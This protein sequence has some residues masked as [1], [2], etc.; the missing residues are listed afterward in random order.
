MGQNTS[1]INIK[2]LLDASDVKAKVQDIQNAFKSIKLPDN[3]SK[4]FNNA[5]DN[6]NKAISNYES[7][8]AKGVKTQTDAKGIVSSVDD[9][10]KQFT[11]VE[12]I[13][14]KIRAEIGSGID[15]SSM[16]K[17]DDA[18]LQKIDTLK[19]KIA[20]LQSQLEKVTKD[21][22]G[23]LGSILDKIS[24]KGAKNTAEKAIDL[25][26]TGK[27]KEAIALL[28]QAKTKQQQIIDAQKRDENNNPLGPAFSES[29]RATAE[30]NITAFGQLQ[31]V[32]NSTGTA[33]ENLMTELNSASSE[34]GNTIKTATDEA[35]EGFEKAGQAASETKEQIKGVRDPL[36]ELTARQAQFTKEVDQV[37]SRIQY[38][39]GL[40][41]SINLVKRA[42]R[43]AVDTIKDLDKA[44]TATAVVTDFT[45]SD[46][47]E[48]LPEYTKRANELG[49]TTQAAYEAATL[50][51][52]QGLSTEEVN[53]LSVETLKMAR[54][55][56]L[57]AA[58]ATDRMTNALR[59]FNMALDEESARRVD[60]VYSE[61][62]ANTASNVD[63]ISTAMTKVAS[64][65]HNANMEFET[66]AAF[67]SQIIETTRES[68]E[69]AGTALKT[70]VARFS[71]VKKLVDEGQLKGQDEEGQAIDVNKVGAALRTAGIDLNKYFLGEVGLDDIFMELAS[72]W[73]TLTNVQQRYIAT[74]AAGSRQQSRFIA[75]M[76]DYARTQE[77][78]DKAY[79]AEGA[80]A[81]QFA[82]TQES[83]ES[84]LARLKNAWNEFL[85]GIT[86]NVVV[87]AVVDGL[88][89]LLNIINKLT[90]AFGDGA[91]SVLKFVT[92]LAALS[93]ARSLFADNG[94]ATK[95]I[96]GLFANT[97]IGNA[98]SGIFGNSQ[99]VQGPPT[100]EGR[101]A[102]QQRRLTFFGGNGL[103]ADFGKRISNFKDQYSYK[104]K[105]AYDTF[106]EIV[107]AGE[108]N[109]YYAEQLQY[110]S[111]QKSL[112]GALGNRFVNGEG[113]IG[114][115]GKKL[116]S[117][118]GQ[119][120]G[121]G[122][123]F[124]G[125][126]GGAATLAAGLGIVTTAA[127][128][129]AAAIKTVYDF[130][131]Q[132]QLK[133]AQKLADSMS[134][135]ATAAK[136]TASELKKTKE[137]NEEYTQAIADS[138]TAS[139]RAEAI[140]NRNEYIQSL[141]EKDATYAKY[142][143]STFENGQLVLTLDED[144][145]AAAADKAAEAATQAAAGASFA[146]ATVAGREAALYNSRIRNAGVD[147]NAR[148]IRD[149]DTE[150]NAFYRQM[151]DNEYAKY[152]KMASD[153]QAAQM[154]M[155]NYAKQAY[156]QL[157]DA[158][159]L[160][161]ELAEELA[162]AMSKTFDSRELDTAN[163][164][165]LRSRGYWENEYLGV[166]GQEADKNLKTADIARA[167]KQGQQTQ[168]KATAVDT[169][170]EL[171]TGPQADLYRSALDAF[172][173]IGEAAE[174]NFDKL[175]E[176]FSAEDVLN[177]LGLQTGGE[178]DTL[179]QLAPLATALGTDITTLR[180]TIVDQAKLN[181]EVQ[182]QNKANIFESALTS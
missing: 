159:V 27:I 142:L 16:I 146:Q 86:N 152:A 87:K 129:A 44:M 53:A 65:A 137:E 127:I 178:L 149:Y 57:D 118:L 143:S 157:I 136:K 54:I 19:Q 111:P 134:D 30:A 83:L 73:D 43:G 171:L 46:M 91:G 1:V 94:L 80:S 125:A 99:K 56:G 123:L 63:E 20:D 68:A 158:D 36:Q 98:L 169:L 176:N 12:S 29:A 140:Q 69:T 85:M 17:F 150:G 153:A 42:I 156:S 78:V 14:S 40:A 173:G 5:F 18:T 48:Q 103:L 120:P 81:R 119:I 89:T 121:I 109:P 126:N 84:K 79:N 107:D 182:K 52:Q 7:K 148:T 144:A 162:S 67:L 167:V 4:Q 179:N 170:T 154:Q 3:L 90:G 96:G 9:I 34:L 66:T 71:E 23:S 122:A 113:L 10:I 104:D 110:Y 31:D 37:K 61:L 131:P 175:G 8:A 38:F 180:K 164:S 6:L 106:K 62:A 174:I 102:G 141:L 70:V 21:A 88:T 22:S 124:T 166:Y 114:K 51:Y 133:N 147:I 74:Q 160:G 139:G 41:N 155:Q 101:Q 64:L 49:V 35:V 108:T 45:V 135:V 161:D 77:L 47:W 100:V 2:A 60:D 112:F 24:S 11:N 97:P 72:K 58:E 115:T 50:Y 177:Q 59:G 32:M 93:G 151:T 95:A 117:S 172:E 92:A 116:Q 132:G 105:T 130:S 138:T 168:E 39:F 26:N 13:I 33:T 163:W 25:F 165:F 76:Q 82:K 128:A 75:L 55:A 181:K 28:E 145:L 15:L